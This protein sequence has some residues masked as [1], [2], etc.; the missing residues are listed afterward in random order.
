MVGK[1]LFLVTGLFCLS[2][3][4]VGFSSCH[5]FDK[6]PGTDHLNIYFDE[7]SASAFVDGM[8]SLSLRIEPPDEGAYL[9]VEYEVLNDKVA[10][11]F[12]ANRQGVVF[13]GVAEGSTI[14]YAIVGDTKASAVINVFP[15]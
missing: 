8:G 11:I 13:Y 3:C 12:Q 9:K 7:S 15:K 5:F 2:L 10:R 4:V 14:M 1:V 6:E